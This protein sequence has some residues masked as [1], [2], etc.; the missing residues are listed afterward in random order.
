LSKPFNLL[1]YT[2]EN[3]IVMLNLIVMLF[4]LVKVPQGNFKMVML[5]L[6]LDQVNH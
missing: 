5:L 1:I 6:M 2:K 4:I 3:Y